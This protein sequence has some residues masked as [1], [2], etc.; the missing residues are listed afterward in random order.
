MATAWVVA[1]A[2]TTAANWP[3]AACAEEW[4]SRP[5][6]FI[7]PFPAGGSTDIA[8]RL[9]GSYI[10]K[11]LGQQIFVENRSG[12][13]GNI[14]MEAAAKSAPDGYTFLVT[15]ESV[16]SNP[17][18]YKMTIDALKDL[19]PIIQISHQPIVL[20]AHPSLGVK[21][22]AELVALAKT[23]PGLNYATGS[24]IGSAQQM[25]VQWFAQI[26]GIELVQVAYRGGAQAIT[27]LLGGQVK[28]GS[29]GSAPLIPY[30]KEGTLLMLAQSTQARSASLPDVPT[31]E[32]AGIKGLVLDQWVGAF[33]PARTPPA[34]TAR[35]A[36]EIA[37]VLADPVTRESFLKVGLD[38]ASRTPEQFIEYVG[39][40]DKKYEQLVKELQIK[41]E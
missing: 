21:S 30:Y 15:G 33:A 13:N 3:T 29:L 10:S 31:F 18:V 5:I 1:A 25:A 28:L 22:I 14:G 35:L 36:A 8:A 20:A 23:K 39:T 19:V 26:A 27:D 4:P 11:S 41:A 2:L 34:I 37:K 16:D 12:A 7:V 9:V 17:H 6:R 32:E 24:G 40:E 38:P